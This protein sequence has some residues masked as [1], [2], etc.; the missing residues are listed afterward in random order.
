MKILIVY[1]SKT[2]NTEKIVKEII[3][4]LNADAEKIIDK[5]IAKES[6]DLFLE[7]KMRKREE[8]LK[9]EKLLKIPKNMI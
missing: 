4:N 6:L 7:E 2:G 8:Q 9:L 3:S 1:Y 5:K